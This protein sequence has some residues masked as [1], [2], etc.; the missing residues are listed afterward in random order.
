[1]KIL[2]PILVFI[3]ALLITFLSCAAPQETVNAPANSGVP[4]TTEGKQSWELEWDKTLKAAQKEGIVSIVSTAGAPVRQ[5]LSD[6]FHKKYDIDLDIMMGKGSEVAARIISQRKAG[7]YMVDVYLG[8][9]TTVQTQLKPAGLLEPLERTFILPEFKDPEI[10]KK[11]WWGGQ[12]RWLDDT[13]TNL[14]IASYS[15]PS[16]AV[17]TNL[18]KP[19]E[20]KGYRDLLDPRWKGKII[21]NDPTQAGTGGKH[22][23]IVG[24]RIMGWEYWDQMLKQN[25]VI[26]VDQRLMVEWLAQGKYAVVL[27]VKPEI[28]QEFEEAGAPLDILSPVEGSYLTSGSGSITYMSKAPH[29]DAAKIFINWLLTQEGQ[30]FFA[31]ALGAPSSRLDV[32]TE[33]MDPNL[34]LKPGLKYVVS[35]DEKFSMEQADH[36]ERAKRLFAPLLK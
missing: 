14:A 33:G 12:L 36:F 3:A 17:N 1:M 18:V 30:T 34:V 15:S 29:P 19:G 31:K 22:F 9:A 23:G 25:P 6:S 27:G 11:N 24:S 5:A 35:D 2:L 16:L 32:S 8:G 21:L 7:L 10:I 20:I 13:H 4:V 26:V 28:V